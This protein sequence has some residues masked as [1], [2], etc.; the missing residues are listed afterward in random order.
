[1][2]VKARPYDT[3]AL[4]PSAMC[5]LIVSPRVPLSFSTTSSLARAAISCFSSMS[6]TSS[7]LICR[8]ADALA[9]RDKRGANKRR[10]RLQKPNNTSC[11]VFVFEY[12]FGI[13]PSQK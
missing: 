6:L 9:K 2:F 13:F 5:L 4:T 7:Q 3:V 12:E 10:F 1:M 11:K 8:A